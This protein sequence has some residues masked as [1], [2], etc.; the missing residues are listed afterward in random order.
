MSTKG[1]WRLLHGE[2]YFTFIPQFICSTCGNTRSTYYPPEKCPEC[3]TENV[4]K[5]NVKVSRME[6]VEED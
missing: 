2:N 4:Y 3:N 6:I 5:G 1:E